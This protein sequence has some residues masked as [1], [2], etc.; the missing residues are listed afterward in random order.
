[1]QNRLLLDSLL[2]DN[3]ETIARRLLEYISSNRYIKKYDLVKLL[4]VLAA[5]KPLL[6]QIGDV[7]FL[8]KWSA[9]YLMVWKGERFAALEEMTGLLLNNQVMRDTETF[10]NPYIP[11]AALENQAPAFLF[12]KLELAKRLSPHRKGAGRKKRFVGGLGPAGD[13]R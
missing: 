2:Q 13:D 12:G 5:D 11:L 9:L 6:C 4:Q 8:K 7:V 10:L 3:A 1:M